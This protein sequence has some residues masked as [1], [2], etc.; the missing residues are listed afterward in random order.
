MDG[1]FPRYST[2][3]IKQQHY[4]NSLD[5]PNMMRY[6]SSSSSSN[7]SRQSYSPPSTASSTPQRVP[8][9][10]VSNNPMLKSS[11]KN[12]WKTSPNTPIV[13]Q[14]NY[15]LADTIHPSKSQVS[16]AVMKPT[17]GS[18][19]ISSS[20]PLPSSSSSTENYMRA[21]RHSQGSNL[22]GLKQELK[23]T[24][25]YP[26]LDNKES[27]P[28]QPLKRGLSKKIRGLLKPHRMQIEQ[29][30]SNNQHSI[31]DCQDS[32]KRPCTPDLDIEQNPFHILSHTNNEIDHDDNGPSLQFQD[33][34]QIDNYAMTV[35]QRGPLLTPTLLSQKF[36]VRPYKRDLFRLRALFIWIVHNIRPDYHQK[37]NDLVLLQKQLLMQPASV[38]VPSKA[39][40]LKQRLSRI[41]LSDDHHTSEE[42]STAA[43][44]LDAMD[45]LQE[46]SELLLENSDDHIH[47]TADDVLETRTCKSSF[48][49]AYLFMVMAVA[50]G[51]EDAQVI[52]GYLK[53][54]KDTNKLENT[55][56]PINHAWCSVKIDGEYRFIDCWLASPFYA[57]NETKMEPH[58]FLTQPLDMIMT[59]LPKDPR[60]QFLNPP[61]TQHAF[62]SLPHVRNAFFWH[63]LQVLDFKS[64]A[65]NANSV[66]YLSLKLDKH[67][68]CYAETEG[69]DG[70]TT[71]GLAQCLTDEHRICKIKAV[72]PYNQSQGWLKVYAGTK[73]VKSST[74]TQHPQ[75][76]EIVH[77]NHYPL[78]M[79]IRIRQ[80]TIAA[81]EPFD[82]VQLYMDRNEF[83][84]QEPQCHR[85]YPL[86]KY[87]FSIRGNRS[88]N[89]NRATTHHKLAIKS[90]SGRLIKLMYY[91][92]DQ[93]YDGTVTVSEAGKWSLI[94][95]LHHT[96]GWYTVA[97]WT[98]HIAK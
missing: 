61:L 78:A 55:K 82:F 70:S 32:L 12:E 6:S 58:W 90:P 81:R 19:I 36:L 42:S 40:H 49:I 31:K 91:P 69:D 15:H 37:R 48:G 96:G 34:S 59:H 35:Q 66:F 29:G 71:R 45:L 3:L 93:T 11:S 24:F 50:A 60:N 17:A 74:T 22:L 9:K 30:A 10:P 67:I 79:C 89:Y 56:L 51:F 88:D 44:K 65:E 52:H 4:R 23:P 84:I 2:P 57:Q 39:S 16:P 76:P 41:A 38:L 77:K 87:N 97:S 27:E 43:L 54:P 80:P 83:Y 13:R 47:E 53:A 68:N 25:W 64:Q 18:S 85:L 14:K 20:S 1:A 33:F 26:R 7:S 8:R 98:C 62:F 86:Q 21:R 73:L 46:E 63:Q 94:C 75:Q 95:M 28:L 92:Q 72:L 5:E